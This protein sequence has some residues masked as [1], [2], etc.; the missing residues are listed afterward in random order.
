MTGIEPKARYDAIADATD[1]LLDRIKDLIEQK[2]IATQ[3]E[4]AVITEEELLQSL[5]GHD[6]LSTRIAEQ[7]AG[8]GAQFFQDP[9]KEIDARRR[10]FGIKVPNES[11]NVG[12]AQQ[13]YLLVIEK[14]ARLESLK[15]GVLE[16]LAD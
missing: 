4:S 1:R 15:I 3:D 9:L 6:D 8:R 11:R 13:E 7:T 14:R 2:Q 12:D 5:R 10:A 16:A